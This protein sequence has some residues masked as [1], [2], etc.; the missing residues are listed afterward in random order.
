MDDCDFLA[1]DDAQ[2]GASDH[3]GD[4]DEAFAFTIDIAF[5]AFAQARSEPEV[6]FSKFAQMPDVRDA[7]PAR[8]VGSQICHAGIA[9]YEVELLFAQFPQ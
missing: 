4:S 8:C 1:V 6:F 3:L 7:F 5:V 2:E 9:V